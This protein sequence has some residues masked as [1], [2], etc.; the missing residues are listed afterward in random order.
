VEA[1]LDF[2]ERHG[3]PPA[4]GPLGAQVFL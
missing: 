4:G 2:A 3:A 1:G